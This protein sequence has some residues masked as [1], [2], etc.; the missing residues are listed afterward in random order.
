MSE[1][2]ILLLRTIL[3][4]ISLLHIVIMADIIVGFL[5]YFDAVDLRVKSMNKLYWLLKNI[6]NP[7]YRFVRRF[8][9]SFG[10]IDFSPAVIL[11]GLSV[12]SYIIG[13]IIIAI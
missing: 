6:T 9:P 2:L 1:I 10:G 11:F 3:S 7:M 12:I 13:Q 5:V 4:V 8:I